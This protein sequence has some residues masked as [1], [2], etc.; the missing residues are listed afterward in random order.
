MLVFHRFTAG[1]ING[2]K[3]AVLILAESESTQKRC[4]SA[5]VSVTPCWG[6]GT[7]RRGYE[8]VIKNKM[9]MRMNQPLLNLIAYARGSIYSLETEQQAIL[10]GGVAARW[11]ALGWVRP[12]HDVISWCGW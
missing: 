1:N 7:E 9:K 4:N 12:G 6:G 5:A 11:L 2:F 8:L 10:N 3:E